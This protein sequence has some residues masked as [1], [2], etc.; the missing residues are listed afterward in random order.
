MDLVVLRRLAAELAPTLHGTRIDQIYALPR[1]DLALTLSRPGSPR[2]WFSSEPDEP[3]LY[4][5]PGKQSAPQRPPGF[6]MALRKRARGRRIHDLRLI[7]EDRVVELLWDGDGSRLIMELIPRRASAFVVG[8]DD[9]VIAV[10]TPRRGRPDPGEQYRPPRARPPRTSLAEL[11][12]HRLARLPPSE[13][14]RALIH[15]VEGMTPLLA[16]E[17]VA[18]HSDGASLLEA[19]RLGFS[20]AD[21]PTVGGYL[22]SDAPLA[23]LR[24]LPPADALVLAPYEL[25]STSLKRCVERFPTLSDAA[26]EYYTLRARLR[27][28]DRVRRAVDQ[29]MRT[30]SRRLA[31]AVGRL[32]AEFPS[33]NAS[34]ALRREGDL[35]LAHPEAQ[36]VGDRVRVPDDY[37]DGGLVSISVDPELDLVTNAQQ[38]YRRAKRIDRKHEHDARRLS[39]LR[40]QLAALDQ[41][42]AQT[43]TMSSPSECDAA[44]DRLARLVPGAHIDRPSEP[45]AG[46]ISGAKSED[47]RAKTPHSASAGI[48]KLRTAEGDVILVG[49]NAGANDRL[50]HEVAARDDWW[51]HAEGPGSHVVLRNPQRLEQ[52]PAKAL[53]RAAGVAAWFSRA[54]SA[55]TVEV[56]W[57]RVQSVRRPKGGAPGEVL[58][59][60]HRS[61]RVQPVRPT[62]KA[63]A[64]G[65]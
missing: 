50:T 47:V 23:Q 62:R 19:A 13:L 46:A 59:Q 22:Y 52:P 16:R 25:A 32:Q 20:S 7:G 38:R 6:A 2:P 34:T 48:L 1:Q 45:E 3:H 15:E 40:Q 31:R 21:D 24:T 60:G 58:L 63:D 12:Q 30:R 43:R 64:R 56:H 39:Q 61:I 35:L 36:I 57:T 26:A 28:L 51:L 33:E 41:L 5:H 14:H 65:D 27:L 44:L 49:R 4:L 10:W 11:D 54:R 8:P 55:A 9:R 18:R 29:P 53:E 37:A 42:A 17:I